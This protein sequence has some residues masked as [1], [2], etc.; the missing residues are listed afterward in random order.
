MDVDAFGGRTWTFGCDFM[1]QI[2]GVSNRIDTSSTPFMV[3]SVTCVV[4]PITLFGGVGTN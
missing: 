2:I 1:S 4:G 3:F